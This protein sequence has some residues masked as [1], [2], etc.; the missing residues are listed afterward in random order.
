VS[1]IVKCEYLL[2]EK[3]ER[4]ATSLKP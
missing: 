2:D 4:S 1:E 3:I